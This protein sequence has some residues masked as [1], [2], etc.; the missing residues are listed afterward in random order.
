MAS[1]SYLVK[2]TS[3]NESAMMETTE[4]EGA[5]EGE[6]ATE[7][8]VKKPMTLLEKV[9]AARLERN[10]PEDEDDVD[11]AR[12]ERNIQRAKAEGQFRKFYPSSRSQ[13]FSVMDCVF[14]ALRCKMA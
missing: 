13:K 12:A 7:P 8:E 6:K 9:R 11:K 2:M 10:A 4:G 14:F 5:V 3:E 1:L